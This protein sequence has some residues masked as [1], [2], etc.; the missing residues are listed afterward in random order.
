MAKGAPIVPPGSSP[1]KWLVVFCET[2]GMR[3]GNAKFLKKR[4]RG[5]NSWNE[6]EKKRIAEIY[7]IPNIVNRIKA[8]SWTTIS[9]DDHM[10]FH[11]W[12]GR[13]LIPWLQIRKTKKRVG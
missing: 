5:G 13:S 2:S 9:S 10:H 1:T 3:W 7:N 12:S 4:W 6:A 8:I 11:F